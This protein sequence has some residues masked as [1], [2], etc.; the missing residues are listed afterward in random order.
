[1][2]NYFF[3]SYC[4]ASTNF[5][6][7]FQW[8]E[9]NLSENQHI[10]KNKKISHHLISK[11]WHSVRGAMT[12]W[13]TASNLPRHLVNNVTDTPISQETGCTLQVTQCTFQVTQDKLPSPIFTSVTLARLSQWLSPLPLWKGK[14][15]YLLTLQVSRYYILDLHSTAVTQ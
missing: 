12:R 11:R 9:H 7:S 5:L 15:Q 4:F 6:I 2:D 14:M 10:F 13:P 3:L 1:M 8:M